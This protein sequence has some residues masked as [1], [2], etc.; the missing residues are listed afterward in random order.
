MFTYKIWDFFVVRE[1]WQWF[2]T[3]YCFLQC[4][5]EKR[6]YH[7]AASWLSKA[8][9]VPAKTQDVRAATLIYMTMSNRF[10]LRHMVISSNIY[11]YLL[12][13]FKLFALAA[14]LL[15]RL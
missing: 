10:A 1:L 12:I 7:N 4:Y 14:I 9:Q 11:N 5:I 8:D 15:F 2:E 13:N 3:I 6:D